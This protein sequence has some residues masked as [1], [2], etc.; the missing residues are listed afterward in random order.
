MAKYKFTTPLKEDQVRGLNLGDIIYITGTIYSAR[1][2]AHRKL[3]EQVERGQKPPIQIKDAVIYHAGPI[4]RKK[5]GEW[6]VVSAGPTT[7]SRLNRVTPKL[8]Q[9]YPVRMLIGKGGMSS[10]VAEAL[11]GRG[12]VYCHYTGGVGVLAAKNIKRIVRVEWL[13]LG[14]PEAVWVFE[15]E[16]FGPLIV[17]MDAKGNSLYEQLGREQEKRLEKLLSSL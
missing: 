15:V 1:D 17:T 9:Y 16:N 13:N 2:M 8:L 5:N 4:V 6:E 12:A 11:K 3:I 7:S 14:I 10:E